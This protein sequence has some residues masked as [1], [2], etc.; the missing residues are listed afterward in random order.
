[1]STNIRC[2]CYD[3]G[4]EDLVRLALQ[5]HW[6]LEQLCVHTQCGTACGMCIPYIRDEMRQA[7]ITGL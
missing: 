4:V 7:G 5:N 3:R 1:M 2:V 6:T